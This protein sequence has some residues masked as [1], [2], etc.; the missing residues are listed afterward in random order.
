MPKIDVVFAVDDL[1][2]F[3]QENYALNKKHYT[4][5]NRMTRNKL[6]HYFQDKGSKV[7]FNTMK[8]RDPELSSH[9]GIDQLTVILSSLEK[10]TVHEVWS[11]S[12]RR[13]SERLGVL[14]NNAHQHHDAK[15][16]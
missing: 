4:V 14:G 7:H 12:V 13:P 10:I 9:Y 5:M 15:T 1:K 6:V 8:V 16:H 11:D 3:H 2:Q